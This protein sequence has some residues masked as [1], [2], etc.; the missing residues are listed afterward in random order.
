MSASISLEA[1]GSLARLPSLVPR[2]PEI[3]LRIPNPFQKKAT[4]VQAETETEEGSL[5]QRIQD[6]L[7]NR[8]GQ[9]APFFVDN[10]I[11]NA[12]PKKKVSH[13]K[14]RLKLYTP[15]SKQIKP[16]RVDRCPACGHY[17]RQLSVCMFCYYEIRNIW[18]KD[19][20]LLSHKEDPLEAQHLS[21]TDKRLIYPGRVE[22]EYQRLLKQTE[23]YIHRYPR[24][25]PVERKSSQKEL[26]E[27]RVKSP[28]EDE[29]TNKLPKETE[30]NPEITLN[31]K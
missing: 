3:T 17:K 4:D 5:K 18:R 15:G 9:E 27:F 11:L 19:V 25:L 12:A 30:K 16:T 28:V 2:L 22:S 23:K 20:N 10:G 1:L 7:D 26:D 8:S 31:D 13:M 29:E 21:E 14:R 6:Y 24:T